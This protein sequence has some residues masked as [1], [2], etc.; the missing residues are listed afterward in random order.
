MSLISKEILC[1]YRIDKLLGKGTFSTVKLATDIRTNEKIAIKILENNNIKSKRDINR[2]NREISIVKKVNH[3]NIVKV[4]KI[5]EDRYKYYILMEY[6]EN[7]ELFNLIIEKRKLTEEESAYYFFQLVNG[8][9]YIHIN[10]IIHRDLKPENL[11][12]T[13]NN[14]LKII[15]FGLSNYNT[16]DNLLS[17]PCGSP[18]YASP[19]MV[20]GKKYNGFTNDIWS[21]GIILYAMIYGYLPFENINNNN[22]LLFKKIRECKVEYSKNN[23][24]LALD[25]LKKILVP[26]CNKRIKINEIKKHRF[27]LKGKY[28]FQRKHK[29][30]NINNISSN[31]EIKIKRKKYSN[32]EFNSGIYDFYENNYK[33]TDKRY[34][35]NKIIT[36]NIFKETDKKILNKTNFNKILPNEK[37]INNNK[38]GKMINI[39]K[40]YFSILTNNNRI[41]RTTFSF[42]IDNT[43]AIELN[44]KNESFS[45]R[46]RNTIII[47]QIKIDTIKNYDRIKSP[48]EETSAETKFTKDNYISKVKSNNNEE[49]F[50]SSGERTRKGDNLK[51]IKFGDKF[52]D[53]NTF[54]FEQ[55]NGDIFLNNSIKK[56]SPLNNHNHDNSLNMKNINK[57][58]KFNDNISYFEETKDNESEIKKII[59]DKNE[60]IKNIENSI[61][62][63]NYK[64]NCKE[65]DIKPILVINLRGNRKGNSINITTSPSKRESNKNFIKKYKINKTKLEK[66]NN[67]IINYNKENCNINNNYYK[68]NI[69]IDNY[70]DANEKNSKYNNISVRISRT[71]D[72]D[73]NNN[74][75]NSSIQC[76]NINNKINNKFLLNQKEDKINN[77]S[78]SEISQ[79]IETSIEKKFANNKQ[80][81]VN[82][83]IQLS[84]KFSSINNDSN[85]INMKN[86][87]KI[88]QNKTKEEQ[89][90]EKES[91]EKN[92]KSSLKY[93]INIINNKTNG[94]Y[95]NKGNYLNKALNIKKNYRYNIN[96]NNNDILD[97]YEKNIN[98]K[99]HNEMRNNKYNRNIIL[100]DKNIEEISK[101]NNSYENVKKYDKNYK[102]NNK[103]ISNINKINMANLPSFTIDMN[104]LN[105]NNNKYLKFYDAIKN[106]L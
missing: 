98:K 8:L 37:E 10:N 82:S 84:S 1:N 19:E 23:C 88:Y 6:C 54:S 106:K 105:K 20:S 41:N 64:T 68:K 21:I 13:K 7:G 51:K 62:Y 16:E 30:I 39:A 66:R 74:N 67:N 71:K 103:L 28:I 3:L 99:N 18:C 76:K 90:K 42:D 100:N 80:K 63:K 92:I 44:S 2:I 4:F 29:D 89:S 94:E 83:N 60:K 95:I 93:K 40:N 73:N 57:Y 75:N 104:I 34:G 25:L 33:L 31:N 14:I 81:I 79:R 86:Y 49:E 5:N 45:Q 9:E 24:S 38:N 26:D 102:L 72:D 61:P 11:L 48:K 27:Y 96:N 46:K 50:L 17:T 15:D 22:D 36:E 78:K 101:I 55:Q 69:S 97:S 70:K 47:P 53:Y 43:S 35:S 12:L 59:G 52:P 77:C 85:N 32:S 91:W 65:K 87:R 58:S 56:L